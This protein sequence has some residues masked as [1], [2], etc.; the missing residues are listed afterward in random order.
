MIEN[1][2]KNIDF[3]IVMARELFGIY[4]IEN[5]PALEEARLYSKLATSL[6]K[7]IK[8]LNESMPAIL[9]NI[10]L[11]KK[12]DKDDKKQ[13]SLEKISI[14][15][16]VEVLVSERGKAEF[17]KE[18][19]I[20][21][22]I[23][24]KVKKGQ[25][26]ERKEV[27]K[28]QTSNFYGRISNRLFLNTSQM[29]VDGGQFKS[30]RLDLRKSNLNILSTTYISMMFFSTVLAFGIGLI[31]M[32]ILMFVTVS[33]LDISIQK[34]AGSYLLRFLKLSWIPIALPALTFLLFYSYPGAE[35]KSVAQRINQE[36]PFVVIHMASISGSGIEPIEIFRII[37]TSREYEFAGREFRKILNQTNLYGYDLS[38]ALRNA[39]MSTP[40]GKFSE[41]LNGMS[42]TINSGG[43]MR[44]F[45]E[46]RAES[47]LLEYRLEREKA[48]KSAE[49]F[50][51]LYISIVIATPMIMMMLLVIISISRISTGFN[52][53]QMTTA[54]I[55]IVAI[56]NILFLAFLH[57][58]QPQY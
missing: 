28:F 15:K 30:L 34:Y 57:M 19:N 36:M 23:L 7:R 16:E 40:S 39:S 18:L 25:L 31:L 47:L 32:I 10:S 58:K 17:L 51:D 52:T 6:A 50:M 43:D 26:T 33:I 41:L 27:D 46:K 20:N 12:L 14:R 49:T 8:I 35:K 24:K 13:E 56:V 54:I 45:F 21:E 5:M 4:S 38:T 1:L 53:A 3:E 55:G 48:T 2:K 11:V 42:V 9:N 22:Q 29:L 44:K 37:A